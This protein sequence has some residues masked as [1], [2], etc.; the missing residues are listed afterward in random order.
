MSSNKNKRERERLWEDVTFL[1]VK[2]V[3]YQKRGTRDWEHEREK[4]FND[5]KKLHKII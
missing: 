2:K 1:E 5:C 3:N 4:V